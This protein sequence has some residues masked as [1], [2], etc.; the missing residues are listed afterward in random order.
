MFSSLLA[1]DTPPASPGLLGGLLS[2]W[3]L[4]LPVAA[5]AAAIYFLLPRP[6]AH[7]WFWGLVAG[8]LALLLGGAL[9]VQYGQIWQETLS[10]YVF[11]A[12][13]IGGGGLL[14][15]QQSPARAA[16]SFTLVVLATCGLFLLLAAPFLMAATIIVY[17]GAIVVTFLFVIMLAQQE[18]RSDAD[19]RSREPLL[20][21]LTGFV[22]LAA[23]L[24]VIKS[25]SDSAEFDRLLRASKDKVAQGNKDEFSAGKAL[26]DDLGPGFVDLA[27]RVD[28]LT[29]EPEGEAREREYQAILAEARYRYNYERLTSLRPAPVALSDLSGPAAS[30]PPGEIRR[31]KDTG[32]PA[33]PAENSAFL[34]RSLFTDYLLAVE[35]GGFLLLVATVGAV[36]IGQRRERLRDTPGTDGPPATGGMP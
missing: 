28:N 33:A 6:R 8:V 34:G 31:D 30:T 24:Y 19:A 3:R 25:G 14:V 17:A 23:L 22:L 10:F 29:L 32:V 4:W 15:T 1:A 9:L 21:T 26:L 12:L 5:G 18:G 36:A 2:Q 11:S 27:S 13:A 35:L 16:L 20:A 7:P